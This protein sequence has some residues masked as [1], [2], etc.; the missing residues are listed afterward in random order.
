MN[1]QIIVDHCEAI[2]DQLHHI[3][4]LMTTM[5]CVIDEPLAASPQVAIQVYAVMAAIERFRADAELSVLTI[6][7]AALV[8]A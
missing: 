7:R 5:I 1:T 3:D 6:S 2:T 8:S 4:G